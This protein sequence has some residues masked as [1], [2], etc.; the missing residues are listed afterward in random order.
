MSAK[1]TLAKHMEKL[2]PKE[3]GFIVWMLN[4]SNHLGYHIHL[5]MLP[6]VNVEDALACIERFDPT[7]SHNL[8]IIKEVKSKLRAAYH[9]GPSVTWAM[10][11]NASRIVKRFGAHPE[12]GHNIPHV[13]KKRVTVGV[14]WSLPKRDYVPDE[15]VMVQPHVVLR[16]S[17]VQQDYW[18]ITCEKKYRAHVTTYLLDYCS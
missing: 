14:K 7:T 11:L 1:R 9:I 17:R 4:S 8:R 6:F 13:Q 16:R 5:G 2:K 15:D 12:R 18:H 10:K 3:K